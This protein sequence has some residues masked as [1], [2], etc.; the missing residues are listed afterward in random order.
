MKPI[1]TETFRAA[2]DPPRVHCYHQSPPLAVLTGLKA[3]LA[4]LAALEASLPIK[5]SITYVM[6]SLAGQTLLQ[7]LVFR[8]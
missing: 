6:V 7:R 5:I 3:L 2:I 8:L 4:I 1:M